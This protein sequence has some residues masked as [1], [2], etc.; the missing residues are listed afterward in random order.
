MTLHRDPDEKATS[1]ER[2]QDQAEQLRQQARTRTWAEPAVL[3]PGGDDDLGDLAAEFADSQVAVRAEVWRRIMPARFQQALL[4]DL[5]AD[6]GA[7]VGEWCRNPA[8]RNL[9]LSGPVGTGKTHAAVAA[10]RVLFDL[11]AQV[12]FLPVVEMLDLLRPGGPDGAMAALCDVDVLVLD[13]VG[14]ERPTDWTAERMYSLINRRWLEQLPTVAT[15][16]L[17][18]GELR[19]A[20]GE[21]MFSRLVDAAVG[22]RLVGPD[23][24]LA[25]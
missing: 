23:R 21:R 15:S 17:E 7:T 24:R 4:V 19:A 25:R 12:R 18:P 16:N 6:A 14:T 3:G 5:D 1:L 22:V 8:G 9:V 20:L 13:D 10:A 2:L 11:G